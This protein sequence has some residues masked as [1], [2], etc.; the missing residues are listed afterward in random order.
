M[1]SEFPKTPSDVVKFAEKNGIKMIDLKF[2]DLPG[3]WQHFSIPVSQFKE[4]TF[5]QGVGFDGSSIRGWQA[6]NES[7]MLVVPDPETARIDPFC[8]IPTLSLICD[9]LDPVTR[10]PYSRDPRYVAKKAE[11][12][13]RSTGLADTAFFGPELEFFVF[14]DVRYD[15]TTNS[16]YYHIDSVEGAWNTG[17]EEFPNLGYKPRPKEGYFPVP[18]TDTMQ[19]LRSEMVI[20]LEKLGIEIEAQHHEVATGGQNEIDMRFGSLTTMA[21]RV[22]YFKYV[23]K[24]VARRHSK[25]ATFMPKP[26]FGDNGTGMHTHQSLWKDGKP[27]FAGDKY[28]GF[29]E[30]GLYYIGGILKHAKAICGFSNPSTN[31]YRRLVPGY[32]APINLAYSSRNRSA[33][34]RIPMYF[35]NPKAK[36]LEFRTPD[37]TC[38]PYFS[39]AA[40]LMAGIDGI[41]NKIH[42]GEPLDKD[43]YTLS[44]EELKKV[45]NV[46]FSLDEAL[47]SLGADHEFL[48]KGDV[49][50]RDVIETWID[51]K[52]EKELTPMRLRPAPHEF[53]L[54]FDC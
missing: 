41:Q 54:Y 15:T 38:N 11:K 51:Y 44:P 34:V 47:N 35:N 32:E 24:N 33:A 26:I 14:D 49:F 27:L 18:P 16:G 12:F 40:Q 9:I 13:I 25:V 52:R 20:E 36:R 22:L 30:M 4:E 53:A 1:A 8:E 45:P 23:I 10:Q 50:T 5:D 7:D 31:S 19:D 42:P 6:I 17:R 28:A 37:P 39:F 21:D 29:S 3:M 46:P 43:I 48:L 2:T